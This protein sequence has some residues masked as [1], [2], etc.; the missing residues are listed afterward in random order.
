MIQTASDEA[1]KERTLSWLS[2]VE[3]GDDQAAYLEKM[4]DDT[5]NWFLSSDEFQGLIT[6]SNVTMYCHGIQGAGKSTLMSLAINHLYTL[7]RTDPSLGIAYIFFS[8]QR[9]EPQTPSSLIACLAKQFARQHNGHLKELEELYAL[10]Y[11]AKQRPS[12]HE[13][14]LLLN[15]LT[16]SFKL[17][18]IIVDALDECRNRSG[19][20]GKFMRSLFKLQ[21]EHG[22]TAMNIL[23]TSRTN[24][25]IKD[26]FRD[27]TYTVEISA[28]E[29]DIL[30]YIN[31]DLASLHGPRFSMVLRQ[32][33]QSK[34][35]EAADGMFLIARLHMN[36]ISALPTQGHIEDALHDL[37]SG[38]RDLDHTYSAAM[39]RL[40]NQEKSTR[41]LVKTILTWVIHAQRPLVIQELQHALAIR[42]NTRGLNKDLLKRYFSDIGNLQSICEGLVEVDSRNIV[43]L[44]HYTAYEYF[45][46]R[47]P[48]WLIAAKSHVASMCLTY[49]SYDIFGS[50]AR[51]GELTYA[52]RLH[53]HPFYAYCA[54]Y[55]GVHVR[56]AAMD[57]DNVVLRFL[58]NK[59]NFT[60]CCHVMLSITHPFY[61][62]GNDEDLSVYIAPMH[63]VA[64]WFGMIG[65]LKQLIRMGHDPDGKDALLMT[66]LMWAVD[67]GDM[68]TV[69]WFLA[70]DGVEINAAD[71][72]Q[73]T[74]IYSPM[75][76]GGEEMARLLV[77]HPD[78]DLGHRDS[79]QATPLHVA[80]MRQQTAIAQIL[81][82]SGKIDTKDLNARD[83]DGW[84]PL[85]MCIDN[86]DAETTRVIL[87]GGGTELNFRGNEGHA[88]LVRAAYQGAS[89]V[90]DL[91]L[92]VDGVDVNIT[93]SNGVTA[94][95]AAVKRGHESIVHSLLQVPGIDLNAWDWIPGAS[96]RDTT[97]KSRD[98]SRHVPDI[99]ST[100][101][102]QSKAWRP[103]KN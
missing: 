4:T 91:L 99:L 14:L 83:C 77:S 45:G 102:S 40:N 43:R 68:S 76:F 27:A 55:W 90:M 13:M 56:V 63:V 74:A 67:G 2:P 72:D 71:V 12:V 88:L 29:D 19:T 89:S 92:Q 61:I 51:K 59:N 98:R 58:T 93:C 6:G 28:R 87:K 8:G 24:S 54:E 60:S 78:V 34:V 81:V 49:L 36:H 25:N 32:Q 11:K 46:R 48:S 15:R 103:A 94:L 31:A 9:D 69:E 57:E 3:Y 33:V 53:E 101:R 20:L 21:K 26:L 97:S 100:K 42:P 66:P 96:R 18:V 41:E 62:E 37:T 1:K 39:L 80:C 5:G 10:H 82:D 79:F 95:H 17:S 7:R 38:L 70:I 50:E 86:G 35:L 64:A 16:S 22:E 75:Y 84:T 23:A 44:T 65:S 30:K 52:A 73:N 85:W 47:P